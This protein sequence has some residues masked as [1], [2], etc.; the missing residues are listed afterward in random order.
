MFFKK[1]KPFFILV[2]F[3][4]L[5]ICF[6]F[7]FALEIE[8]PQMGGQQV[9]SSTSFPQYAV[10]LFNFSI[11]MSGIIAFG[12]LVF[13]GIKILTS[14]DQ[15]DTIQDARTKI[16]GAFLGI[17]ILL[18]S[19]LILTTMNPQFIMF[20]LKD[21][22]PVTGV[23]LT[24]SNGKDYYIA[25]SSPDV[26]FTA[27]NVKF[28]SPPEELIAV[29]D[30]SS[31]KVDNMGVG[32]GG[33]F[34]GK[35][36]YFLWN[37]PGIYLY[38]NINFVGQPLYFNSSV[39][40][41][42]NYN[43]DKKAKSIIFRYNYATSA[44]TAAYGAV[45]FN[46]NDYGGECGFVSIDNKIPDLSVP[47]PFGGYIYPMPGGL[48]SF[49]FFNY[50]SAASSTVIFWDGPNCTGHRK[51]YNIPA[52]QL[53]YA[54]DLSLQFFDDDP[55]ISL[56]NHIVSFNIIGNFSVL[57]S[58]KTDFKGKCEIFFKP[59]NTSCYPSIVSSSLWDYLI[60]LLGPSVG[61]WLVIPMAE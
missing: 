58:T 2:S 32:L 4:L 25:D 8:Y 1:Q 10:Y 42:S 28:I 9:A 40:S 18:A 47:T 26:G 30:S 50:A 13:S 59:S 3:L 20:G 48:S 34:S 15:P 45:F 23:Y 37:R 39:S 21:I 31:N 51:E 12:V 14:P 61:T 27:T 60:S 22:K 16:I 52:S 5:F 44:A 57:L 29:Y 36:I 55:T 43:F 38:P 54:K 19:Y 53:H 35:S 56:Q 17:V 46:Q 33:P 49:Y 41:L 11:I 7:V 6:S 24:D